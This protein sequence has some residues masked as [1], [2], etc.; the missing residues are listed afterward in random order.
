[1]SDVLVSWAAGPEPVAPRPLKLPALGAFD[2]VWWWRVNLPHRKG[3][4]CRVIARGS[5][6]SCCIEFEDGERH[7]CSRFA[8]RKAPA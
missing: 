8:V 2:R 4:R 6:N 5:M 7:I 1:M 3:D